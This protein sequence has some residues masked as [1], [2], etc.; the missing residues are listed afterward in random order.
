MIQGLIVLNY[1]SYEYQR[2]HGTLLCYA[3][4]AVSLFV[5]TYLARVLPTIES[6]I[7]VIHILGFFAILI[8]LVYLTP[9]KSAKEVFATFGNTAGWSSDGL[10]FFVGLST[11]MFAFIGIDAAGHIA[12]EIEHASSV[13][14]RSMCYSVLINGAL[15]F[16]MCIALLFCL[17]DIDAAL[18][19]PTGFPFIEVYTNGV[20]S[21]VGGTAMASVI[22]AAMIFA[23]IAAL[24]TASRMTWAF[25][26]EKG[27]PGS[28]YISRVD[29]RTA[30]PLYSIG[31]S[32]I[33]SFLLGLINIGS[34]TVF[35]AMISLMI[36][37]FYSSIIISASVM[38]YKRLTVP[39]SQIIWGPFKLGRAGV[40]VTI[41]AIVYSLIGIFFSFW[42]PSANVTAEN[43]NW[44]VLVFGAVVLFLLVFWLLYGRHVYKGP[45]I[46]TGS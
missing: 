18:A 4:I 25:A 38:L 26:R 44:S 29:S 30:L 32:T 31:L 15:G 16:A 13:I 2:W 27:L 9:H 17:G 43:M 10:S 21:V 3:V 46:E 36:A 28:K 37:S 11:S 22:I 6:A 8:T 5:N 20:G 14:P 7:L 12:E 34:T 24:A 39:D 33:I 45:I 35:N 23:T 41:L 19:T 1:E 40:P 42:P